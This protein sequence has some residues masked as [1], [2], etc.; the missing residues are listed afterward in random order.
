MTL[1]SKKVIL[2]KLTTLKIGG[3]AFAFYK[4]PSLPQLKEIIRE[5]KKKNQD[6][7]ILGNG[8]NLLVSDEGVDRPVIKLTG[9]F[10]AI[11]QRGSSVT[12][13]SAVPLPRLVE[14]ARERNLSGTEFLYG[15]PGT[16][17]GALITN[18][19]TNDQWISSLI[20]VVFGV[21]K[22]G[23]EKK[24]FPDQIR[25]G[26]RTSHFPSHFIIAGAELTL[27]QRT[28]SA[29]KKLLSFYQQRRGTQPGGF[30]AG[31]IFKNPAGD[32][33]GRLIER[34]GLK[35]SRRGGAFVSPVHANFIINDQGKAS[36]REVWN[37]IK[38]VQK[39]VKKKYGVSLRLEVKTWGRF[40]P[41][42]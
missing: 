12:V 18:A 29:I 30:S 38:Y 41:S 15:L 24:F 31:C 9:E 32:S 5:L 37:L 8:S 22:A 35:N 21:T 1:Q 27:H 42:R 14:Y 10:A 28:E 36:G 13:G 11:T 39:T 33:A 40:N 23:L 16:V 26:Y 3:P 34:S 25:F 20:Q 7:Y 19:G 4:I 6:Y 17:G 2:K